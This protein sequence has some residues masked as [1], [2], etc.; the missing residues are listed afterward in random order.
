MIA[1]NICKTKSFH[2]G[3]TALHTVCDCGS[4]PHTHNL[5]ME[6]DE[7]MDKISLN[8][9]FQ[10]WTGN[11]Y[12]YDPGIIGWFRDVWRSIKFKSRIVFFGY[13]TVSYEFLF[14]NETAVQNYIDALQDVLNEQRTYKADRIKIR[15][16]FN[17]LHGRI[18][19]SIM[20]DK[21]HDPTAPLVHGD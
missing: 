8:M 15:N 17:E 21:Q 12:K 13:A 6:Y 4:D 11:Q 3:W 2:N 1:T 5:I 9:Y 18:V 7:D 19:D 20:A 10:T 16:A 14:S